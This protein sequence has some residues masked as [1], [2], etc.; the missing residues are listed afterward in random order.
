MTRIG[1]TQDHN[2]SMPNSADRIGWYRGNSW[3]S[4]VAYPGGAATIDQGLDDCPTLS[5]KLESRVEPRDYRFEQWLDVD[6]H[7]SKIQLGI[8][9][10]ALLRVPSSDSDRHLEAHN[11]NLR[12]HPPFWEP[13]VV[14]LNDVDHQASCVGGQ[15]MMNPY[16]RQVLGGHGRICAWSLLKIRSAVGAE[17]LLVDV[18]G[19][20][21][22]ADHD[23]FST[24]GSRV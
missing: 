10:R 12:D 13:V 6:E 24:L 22:A 20:A 4:R 17:D 16:H 8:D 9:R 7:M 5:I 1:V 21:R 19:I 15:E 23:F 2:V 18:R 3:I 14:D 11:G